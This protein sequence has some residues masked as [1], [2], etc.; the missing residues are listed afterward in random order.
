MKR[1]ILII[2]VASFFIAGCSCRNDSSSQYLCQAPEDIDDGLDV[3]TLD[4]VDMD[5]ALLSEAVDRIQAG[6]YG[7]VHSLLIYKDGKLVFEEYFPGHT[8]KWDGPGFHGDWV[9][10]D[11]NQVHNIHSV[12]KSMTTACIGIAID[13]GFIESVD[14]SIFEYLPDYQHLSSDG[15]KA[16]TIEHLLTMTSGLDWDEWGTSYS[17]SENDVI[18]LWFDCD[19]QVACILEEPLVG[20][21][22]THFTYS[23]GNTILLGEIIK[24]ATQMDIE[25]FSGRYLFEPLAID[26]PE[27]VRFDSGMIYAGG[28][29]NLTPRDMVKFGV[30][31]LDQGVWNGQQI[32][33]EGWVE[34]SATPYP[35]PENS[36][37]NHS[38]RS[39]PPGDNTWGQR[40]YSYSWWTHEYSHS[41]KQ[42]SA[43]FAL[44]FGGQKIIVFPD[45]NAVVVFTAGN[46][47]SAD[48]TAKVL[49]KYVIPAFE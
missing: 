42:I 12:G 1:A 14:Q 26:P 28:D 34:K 47:T 15:K 27:W 32:I 16:I 19:D 29:Q 37:L 41:G 5:S 38:L 25:E 8:Y 6:K 31:Y 22:G 20:E 4:E 9:E 21:P 2:S 18:R 49:T 30:T 10:W 13:Q 33:T 48:T 7:E 3:G 43:F 17:D 36:W 46:Y 45:Q 35:G 23:G 40:G 11:E 44:G 24:N 39:I